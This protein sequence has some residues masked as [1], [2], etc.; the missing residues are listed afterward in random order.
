MVIKLK[1]KMKLKQLE[2]Q[3]YIQCLS[4][5]VAE[6]I[7]INHKYYGNKKSDSYYKILNSIFN[8]ISLTD[9]DLETIYK[10]VDQILTYKYNYII[11]NDRKDVSIYLVDLSSERRKK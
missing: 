2:K 4:E 11:A 8:I 9:E 5:L 7:V 6:R 1:N 3:A 10:L